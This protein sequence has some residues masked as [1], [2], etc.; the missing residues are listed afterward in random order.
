MPTR[1]NPAAHYTKNLIALAMGVTV[2]RFMM[3]FMGMT[4]LGVPYLDHLLMPL[5]DSLKQMVGA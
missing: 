5:S 4:F 2:V 1:V 3:I